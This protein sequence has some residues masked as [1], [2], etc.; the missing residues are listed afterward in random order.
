MEAR[1]VVSE[2]QFDELLE[3]LERPPT[4]SA[5]SA[6]RSPRLAAAGRAGSYPRQLLQNPR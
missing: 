2:K 3:M 1:I 6:A 5:S 4:V